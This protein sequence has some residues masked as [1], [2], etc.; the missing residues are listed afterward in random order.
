MATVLSRVQRKSAAITGSPVFQR[1]VVTV[2][3]LAGVI[4]GL[5]TFQS[6]QQQYGVWLDW[7]DR[8]I[9]ALFTIEIFLK[10]LALLP[11]PL[12]FFRDGWN[13]FDFVIVAVC[14]LPFGGFYV[15]A[16]RLF[17]LLRVLRLIT[18]IPRLQTLVSA[19]LKSLPSMGYVI[20]L[21]FLLFYVYAVLGVML[22]RENDPVHFGNIWIALLSLF[23]VVT[24]EGWVDLMY[25]QMWGSDQYDG[26]NQPTDGLPFQPQAQPFIAVLY[27]VSFVFVG[28]FVMLNL[29]IG[30]IINSMDEAQRET[31]DRA[32]HELL[33]REVAE[34]TQEAKREKR[35]LRLQTQLQELARDLEKLK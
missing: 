23:R 32:L 19:M 13:N 22:F 6:V 11:R 33:E 7:L 27:F 2:I 16:L 31:A 15:S 26:Y 9:L 3:I 14:F 29:V 1:I 12:D 4:V 35:I 25:L 30:I 10:M 21:L 18:V 5:G 34:G 28:T 20:L 17:R 8:V 24:L